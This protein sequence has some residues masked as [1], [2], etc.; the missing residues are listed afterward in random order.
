MEMQLYVTKNIHPKNNGKK[1]SLYL[2]PFFFSKS[3]STSVH[4]I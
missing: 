3:H 1:E 4:F 2:D